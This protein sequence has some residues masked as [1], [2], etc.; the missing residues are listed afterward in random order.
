MMYNRLQKLAWI[1]ELRINKP[2]NVVLWK[3]WELFEKVAFYNFDNKEY[4]QKWLQNP[5]QLDFR[6]WLTTLSQNELNRVYQELGQ[7]AKY[8]NVVL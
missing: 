1:Q 6:S 2:N 5:K 8:N 4:L 3:I 7:I